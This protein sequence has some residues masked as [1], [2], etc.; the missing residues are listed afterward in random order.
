MEARCVR[1]APERW[2]LAGI[3]LALVPVLGGASYRT[4]NFVV[5]APTAEAAKAVGEHAES[6]RATIARQWLGRELAPWKV[7]C[8]IRVKLTPG[9]AGGV[10]SFGFN[11]G[12][13]SDQDMMVEGRLD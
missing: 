8:P 9:E 11:H 12:H 5:E 3:V 6:C 10:T 13:V 4:A 7:P 1:P 2:G